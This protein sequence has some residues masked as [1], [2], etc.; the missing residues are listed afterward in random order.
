MRA[1][2]RRNGDFPY[3]EPSRDACLL[4]V[5]ATEATGVELPVRAV[6]GKT[7]R[8]SHDRRHGQGAL[9]SV[10]VWASDFGLS[11]GQVAYAEKSND[12]TAIPEPPRTV[13]IHGAGIPIDMMGARK[14]IANQIVVCEQD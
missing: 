12:I 4:G 2:H 8:R 5:T 6:G 9:H 11:L 7:A 13:D 10:S 1:A 14:T 3:Q